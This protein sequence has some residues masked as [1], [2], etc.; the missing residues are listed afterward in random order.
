MSVRKRTWKTAK[1]EAKECWIVD[2]VDQ[3][4]ERRGKNFSRKKDADAYHARVVVDVSRGAHTPDSQSV[5]VA[6]AGELWVTTAVTNGLERT[7]TEEYSRHLRLHIVPHL[8]RTKLSQLSA[9]AVR[10]FED[11]LR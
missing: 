3:K 6:E 10:Q 8:G 11:A 5:T 2:Y 1:G 4:G 7:T 9:P